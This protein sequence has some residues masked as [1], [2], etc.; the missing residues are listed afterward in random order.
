MTCS[1]TIGAH[2]SP[3]REEELVDFLRENVDFFAWDSSCMPGVVGI[4]YGYING[5]A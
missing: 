4:L 2:L 5:M 1:V 3:E